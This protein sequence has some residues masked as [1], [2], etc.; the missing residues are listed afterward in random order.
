[1]NK[2]VIL[3]VCLLREL[4]KQNNFTQ[5]KLS[6]IL[7]YKSRNSY[8]LVEMGKRGMSLKKL[9][10]LADLYNISVDELLNK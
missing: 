4:R 5:E 7:G 9:S 1:M 8:A 3:N 6:S 2:R 10:V